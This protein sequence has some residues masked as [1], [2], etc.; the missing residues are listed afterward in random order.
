MAPGFFMLADGRD[1]PINC[2]G[3]PAREGGVSGDI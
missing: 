2:G 3:E 1:T